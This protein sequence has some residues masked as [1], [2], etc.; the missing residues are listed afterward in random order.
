MVREERYGK[1]NNHGGD[2]DD[3]EVEDQRGESIF[4]HSISYGF[5]FFP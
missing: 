4:Y 5:S 2:D 1:N 3:G